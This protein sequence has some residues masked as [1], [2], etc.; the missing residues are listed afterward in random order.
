MKATPSNK[1]GGALKNL[2]FDEALDVSGSSL[3]KSEVT[4]GIFNLHVFFLIR[5]FVCVCLLLMGMGL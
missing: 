5:S 3:A 1:G 4:Y 2:P